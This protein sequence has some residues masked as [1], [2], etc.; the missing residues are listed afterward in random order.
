MSTIRAR[1]RRRS[2]CG[3]LASLLLCAAAACGPGRQREAVPE[4]EQD[5]HG[6][7]AG[8]SQRQG[9]AY[10]RG[11]AVRSSSL[12]AGLLSE[13]P[14]APAV[15]FAG[16]N[17]QPFRVALR[18]PVIGYYP[19]TNCHIRPIGTKSRTLAQMHYEGPEHAGAVRIDC[20]ACHD[21]ASPRSLRLDCTRCHER[22]GTRDLMPSRV[23]HLTIQLGHPG[24]RY[25]NCLTCHAPENPGLLAL[26]DGGRATLDEAYRLCGGCHFLEAREWA[27]GAHGKRLA[28]WQGERVVLSCTGCH[29]PHHPK[30]PVRRPVTFPKLARRDGAR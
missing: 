9:G 5:R 15:A 19:C 29:D 11:V 21:P 8:P 10:Q 13:V 12:V 26:Q 22:E 16:P 1:D 6:E 2:T 20:F 17:G 23:A 28:G 24:G 14:S 30:F 3:I 7:T 25:R 27:G 4:L 18:T